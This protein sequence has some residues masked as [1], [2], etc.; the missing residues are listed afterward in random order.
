[1]AYHFQHAVH[2]VMP[3]TAELGAG[4][5]VISN[6]RGCEVHVD[7]EAGHRILLEAHVWN[8]KAVD[9]VDGAQG[10]IDLSVHGQYHLAGDDIVFRHR[11]GSVEADGCF[12]AC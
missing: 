2:L 10:E 5:L 12:T 9:H 11:I 8:K 4:N 1:R 7:G 6:G 3:E